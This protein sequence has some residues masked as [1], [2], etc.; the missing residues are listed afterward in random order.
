MLIARSG[1][2]QITLRIELPNQERRHLEEKKLRVLGNIG[3]RHHQISGRES[4]KKKK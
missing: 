1:K 2:R 3:S 4:K